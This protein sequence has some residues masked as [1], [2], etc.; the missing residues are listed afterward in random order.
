[1]AR[2]PNLR[3][4][5]RRSIQ[6]TLGRFRFRSSSC[7]LRRQGPRVRVHLRPHIRS[8]CRR[9]IRR[10]L[11]PDRPQGSAAIVGALRGGGAKIVHR[12]GGGGEILRRGRRSRSNGLRFAADDL[13]PRRGSREARGATRSE[14]IRG[15]ARGMVTGH[16]HVK[17]L[18]LN[19]SV[20][21][22]IDVR[23]RIR[24]AG[25]DFYDSDEGPKRNVVD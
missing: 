24:F 10:R 8:R 23:K 7:G 4:W 11:V 18:G 1:M 13:V 20:D 2:E 17:C 15:M 6:Q 3:L 12:N 9:A 16:S 21:E 25:S 19:D 22:M 14:V 5:H